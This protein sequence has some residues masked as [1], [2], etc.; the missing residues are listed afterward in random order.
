MNGKQAKRLR[1]EIYGD[2][3]SRPA[4]LFVLVRNRK[5]VNT[6][7]YEVDKA[8]N[9]LR[10]TGR[11]RAYQQAKKDTNYVLNGKLNEPTFKASKR[12]RCTQCWRRMTANHTCPI[13]EKDKD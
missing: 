3:S 12:P 6:D 8:R 11:R 9:Q 4:V 1:K 13:P 7:A 5:C 2:Y 10:T